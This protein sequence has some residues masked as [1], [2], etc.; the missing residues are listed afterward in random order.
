MDRK[1]GFGKPRTVLTNQNEDLV[2][3]LFCSQEDNPESHLSPREI[4]KH[5]GIS[6][7]SVRKMVKSKGLRQFK[8]RQ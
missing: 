1:S 2:D 8:R 5:T 7:S 6:R 3:E 4:E